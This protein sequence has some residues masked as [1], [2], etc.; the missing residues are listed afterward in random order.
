[1]SQRIR[2]RFWCS[3]WLC[4]S[5]FAE[6]SDTELGC[7]S[8]VWQIIPCLADCSD[9][10]LVYL[11]ADPPTVLIQADLPIS[12]DTVV[13]YLSADSQAIPVQCSTPCQLIRWLFWY[14]GGPHVSWQIQW[15]TL[16]KLIRFYCF[17]TVLSYVPADLPAVLT[18]SLSTSQLNCRNLWYRS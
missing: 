12:S 3:G 18:Q 10:V 9:T 13:D 7:V 5:W 2:G 11:S 4:V 17:D 6:C 1:M 16:C 8:A 15:L 14:S